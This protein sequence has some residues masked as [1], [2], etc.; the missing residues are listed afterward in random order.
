[1]NIYVFLLTHPK[2][3]IFTKKCDPIII[4]S[5]KVTLDKLKLKNISLK[6]LRMLRE[7]HILVLNFPQD[8]F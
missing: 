2:R 6:C 1:M 8:Y 7:L 4:Y 5:R 3:K